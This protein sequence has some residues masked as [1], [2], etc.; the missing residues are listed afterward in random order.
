M[1][2]V[3]NLLPADTYTVVNKTIINNEDIKLVTMLYQ[4]IIGYTAV[5]LY[6]SLIN[7]LDKYKM[8]SKEYTHHHLIS[9]MQLSLNEIIVA[10]EKLEGIGLLKTYI[11][12][13]ESINS[14][15]YI[16][17]SPLS[18]HEFFN[19]PILN[20]VLYN[21][22]GKKEYNDL[23]SYYKIPR[24][25]LKDYEEITK[26][27]SDVYKTAP[28]DN[29]VNEDIRKANTNNLLIDKVPD[30]DLLLSSIPKS[31]INQKAFTK[32]IKDLIIALIYTYNLSTESIVSLIRDSLNEKG[33]IDKNNL[34]KNCRNYY[35]FDNAGALPTLIYRTQ[36]DFLKKPEGDNSNWAKMV[37]TFENI[38]PYDYLKA[39]YKG[40]E[41]TSRDLKLIENLLIE[42]KL[43]PGVVNVLIAYVLKINNQKLNKN[44]IETIAGQWKR[45]NIETVEEAMKTTEKEY[46]KHNKSKIQKTNKNTKKEI[47]E[48]PAWFNKDL[49]GIALSKEEEEEI[50]SILESI[51]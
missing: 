46:Q 29:F 35:Q 15:V 47:K 8:M 12:S 32:D 1:K 16:L 13:G 28:G 18:A 17:Y 34:R 24:F 19:H 41:P 44:Y 36:P 10:R 37:Y 14:Y 40:V 20:V 11:K 6:L 21:N 50:N 42:Q 45:L 30:F 7:D 49:E 39:K 26:T 25:A 3:I 5:S 4:P 2:K 33:M 23:I 38:S 31:M 22:L 51:V 27:F 9:N 48:V 43:S